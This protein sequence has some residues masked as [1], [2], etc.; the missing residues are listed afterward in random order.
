MLLVSEEVEYSPFGKLKASYSV[1][2]QGDA[3]VLNVVCRIRGF[4]KAEQNLQAKSDL[5]CM[6]F[7]FGG[8]HS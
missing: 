1:Q 3:E 6:K 7:D 5:P 8:I 2:T 4:V